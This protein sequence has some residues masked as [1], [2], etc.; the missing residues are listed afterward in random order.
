MR[1]HTYARVAA[2]Y[3]R[4]TNEHR[5]SATILCHRGHVAP[6]RSRETM[7]VSVSPLNIRPQAQQ[8]RRDACASAR[9]SAGFEW[10]NGGSREAEQVEGPAAGATGEAKGARDGDREPVQPVPR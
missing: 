3:L 7:V 1:L 10:R 2:Q 8:Q 6:H 9:R 5:Q 4:P